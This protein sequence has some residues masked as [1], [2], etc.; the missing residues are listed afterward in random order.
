[1]EEKKWFKLSSG[2]TVSELSTNAEEGLT[3]DEVNKRYEKYGKNELKAKPKK[4][5]IQK[6]IDQFK[7][8]MIIVLIIAAVV[9]GIVGVKQ[10]EGMADTF[11]ILITGFIYCFFNNKKRGT[12]STCPPVA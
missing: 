5:L 4:S 2:Q 8:F 9:S 1:M 6:F 7:D 3:Q 11:I 10:G 12:G